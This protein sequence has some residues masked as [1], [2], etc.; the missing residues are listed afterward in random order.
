MGKGLSWTDYPVYEVPTE[1]IDWGNYCL[2]FR[3]LHRFVEEDMLFDLENDY[4]QNHNLHDQALKEKMC[5][6]MRQAMRDCQS[7]E[8]QFVRMGL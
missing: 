1:I 5:R 2:D 3:I 8:E 4:E 7:P 6:L